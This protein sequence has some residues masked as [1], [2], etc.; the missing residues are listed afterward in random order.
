MQ[1][2][3][4]LL[5]ANRSE[6]A[7]RIFR[8]GHELG[9]GTVAVYAHEDRYALHRFK[10]DEAYEIGAPGEPIKSY[11]DVEALVGLAV[12]QS[13]DA[14]HPGYGFLSESPAL[15]RACAKAGII[16]VGPSVRLLEQL[17]DKVAARA[18]GKRAGVPVLPGSERPLADAAEAKRVAK[19]L[20]YPVLLKAA[21]GGGG[22]GMRVVERAADVPSRFEEAQRESMAAFGSPDLFLERYIARPRHIEVQ[23]LGDQ[24]GHLVH[25]YERDCSVQRRH[26]KVVEIAPSLLPRAARE[27][28][29]THALALGRAAGFDNAGTVEFLLD[30]D[31]GDCFFIEVNPRIQVEHTVTEAV[32][33]V[34]IVKAQILAAQGIALDDDRI[35]LPSQQAVSVRGHAI[36][37]RVTTEVPENSFIPDY[38][39]ITHYRSPG[40]MGVRL[41]A[42]TAFSGAVVTPH[43]DSLLVKVVTS[44][45]RFPDAARRMERCLQEFRVRG[46]K[47]NLPF[48][49]NLVLHPTF[50]EGACTTHFID[51]TP[52]LLEFSAPRDRATKLCTYLAEVAIN[53]HPLVPERPADVRREP[54]PLPPHHGQQPIPDGT[55]DRL[56]RMGA[57][58]FCGWIRR[59]RP[60]LVTDT[61]FRDAHQSLLATRIRTYDMLAVADLYARRASTLFSLEM[62][63]GATFDS[64]MRFLK[65]SPW[66]RLT[67]LRERIPNILFQMLL[68]G[69]NGV[70]Y[71][72]YPDNVVRAFVAES[73]SAGID[74]FRIFDALNYLPNMKAAMDAVRRTD[75]L[76]EAAIC[77][78]GDILDPDR[79]K[80]S[81][82][83]YVGLA[84]K[85]EKMGAHLLAIK[86]MA[87]LCKPYAA[88]RLVKALRQ[89]TDLPI[90]FHTH[91]SAGVQ[92]AAVLKATEAGLDIADAAS[93]PLSGMTSQP[94]MDGIVEALRFTKRDT[95]LDGEALQQIAEYWEAARD[96]YQPFEAGMRA[97]SADVYRHEMPGGQ[98][99]N[100]RQQAASLGLA[101][102]WHEICRAYEDANRLLG[103]VIKVTPSSKAIG[104]LAL[105]LVTNN[106]SADAI[107]TSERELAFPDSVVELVAGGLGQPHGGFPPKVRQRI[108]RGQK[109]KRGR[110]GAGLPAAD[111]KAVRATLSDELGR[112]ASRRDVLSHLMF[113][114]VFA[115]FSAH[116]DRYSDVSVLP[117]PS[118]LYGL[119][120]GE[121]TVVEIERGKTLLIRLVAIGE[122]NDDGVRTIFFELN[123][124]PRHVTVQDRQLTASAP[125]H[126][127][128]DPADPKQLAAAMPGL[129]TLVAVKPGDRV[130]RGEKL[131]SLEAMKMET[132]IYAERDGEVAE[133]LVHP[134]TQVVA[135]DLVIRLA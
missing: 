85:L 43:Y 128:A 108:L 60:L 50:L 84:K 42:G 114:K 111:L 96:F 54:V 31:T 131:L 104:D 33:G 98:T 41:D 3:C 121:E 53:G 15:A 48:L 97:A 1:P 69:A 88:E 32:T 49:I 22:R 28:V 135:G 55:R 101:S 124:Q 110:P 19:R 11:L 134:G 132:S 71:G 119:E 105:Y 65:E 44:G 106:L 77:Y 90:H 78:T 62:W 12:E 89:E 127:Q 61:T 92:A 51:E 6:I 35:G 57:E 125:A 133:V 103:D 5:V 46:V 120:P 63:G 126:V 47:T 7:I 30:S 56:R 72:T 73:A 74:V 68:R 26:Q 20:G 8:A 123:G 40:G 87:G 34:D 81:L 83:Y 16:F 66:D 82:D 112:P 18:L 75:A 113:P 59:Q 107:L 39:K 70:G 117:T 4:R 58:R 115:E 45:Q 91:D 9:I 80:Y 95:G 129:V 116:E 109:P 14:I 38:G 36:Q 67:T 21:K 25:L 37:C 23:L 13:I 102:R 52:E 130:S 122:P 99:T 79:T 76:C 118:F 24:H 100:L 27:E 64:A 2:I 93:G 86:D 29:C 17:G 94:I 10:A